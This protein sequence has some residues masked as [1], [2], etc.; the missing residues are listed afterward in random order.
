[1]KSYKLFVS[2]V[3]EAS[4][5][6]QDGNNPIQYKIKGQVGSPNIINVFTYCL[7]HLYVP[8]IYLLI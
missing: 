5:L 8:L 7:S 4:N 6:M 1:M 3:E 2:A